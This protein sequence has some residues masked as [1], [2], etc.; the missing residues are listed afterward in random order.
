MLIQEDAPVSRLCKN[1]NK[2]IGPERPISK[3]CSNSCRTS[4]NYYNGG[5]KAMAYIEKKRERRRHWLNYYKTRK[6]CSE[7]GYCKYP[8]ALHF[9]HLDQKE[10]HREVSSMFGSNLK[11]LFAEIR[12]CRVMCANCHAHHS[13]LQQNRK[14]FDP[15]TGLRTCE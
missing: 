14:H 6:G 15:A 4:W 9:D 10:K 12:K 8:E 5:K 1:C 2:E 3:H 13:R 7:C 11:K